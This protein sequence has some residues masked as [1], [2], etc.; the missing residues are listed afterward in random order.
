[1]ID[2]GRLHRPDLEPSRRE[3]LMNTKWSNLLM[4]IK[5]L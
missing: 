1:M 3:T 2:G 5:M 4:F